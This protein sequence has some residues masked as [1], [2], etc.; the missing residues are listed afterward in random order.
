MTLE[1]KTAVHRIY[2]A[3][4]R[5]IATGDLRL[6]DGVIATDAVDHNPDPGM[7]QGLEGIKEAFGGLRVAFPDYHFAV[8]DVIMEGEKVACRLKTRGTH[9]GMFLGVAA[10]QRPVT[11]SGIDI[12]RIRE[13]KIVERWGAFDNA[14]FL[15][16]LGAIGPQKHVRHG[17]GS[18]RPYVYGPPSL[19]ELVTEAL[20]AKV[21]ERIDDGKGAHVEVRLGDS[22]IVLELGEFDGIANVTRNSIYVYVDDVDRVYERALRA[23]ASSIAAPEAKPYKERQAGVMDAFGNVWWIASYTGF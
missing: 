5:A 12:L 4:N 2:E 21:V 6:L 9:R 22:M 1:A 7:K 8:E 15:Q 23:G 20:G 19:F 16:Q 13:G 11:L 17:I 10:T 18:V 14:S 3:F